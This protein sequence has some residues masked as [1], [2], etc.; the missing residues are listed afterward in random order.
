MRGPLRGGE[1]RVA[2]SAPVTDL[3]VAEVH[4]LR[5]VPVTQKSEG[6]PELTQSRRRRSWE[7]TGRAEGMLGLTRAKRGRD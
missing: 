7:V 4:S 3:G 5:R 6:S 2:E 1:G